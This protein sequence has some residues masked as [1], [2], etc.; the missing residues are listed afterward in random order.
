MLYSSL[1]ILAL[2][3]CEY[4]NNVHFISTFCFFIIQ[5]IFFLSSTLLWIKASAKY[6]QTK[7]QT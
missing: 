5:Y 7:T 1:C 3:S 2:V 6:K 4:K